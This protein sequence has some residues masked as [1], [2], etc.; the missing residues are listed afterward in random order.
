MSRLR[1]A[2]LKRCSWR[3]HRDSATEGRAQSSPR[4]AP[5]FTRSPVCLTVRPSVESQVE[6]CTTIHIIKVSK[7]VCR[8]FCVIWNI[9]LKS[10]C[11]D[12]FLRLTSYSELYIYSEL[13]MGSQR[14]GHDWATELIA[15]PLEIEEL[16][17]HLWPK[18]FSSGWLLWYSLLATSF[19]SFLGG[20]SNIFTHILKSS[21]L[22]SCTY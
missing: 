5:A 6:A 12:F 17:L 21:L 10:S 8:N 13:S 3:L 9:Q 18:S 11:F 7:C 22:V 4:A 14:V 15:S 19:Y 16:I 2:Q 20:S 1:A